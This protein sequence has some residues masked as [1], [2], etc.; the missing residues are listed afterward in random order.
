MYSVY[1]LHCTK[2]NRRKKTEI[3]MG[4]RRR[5]GQDKKMSGKE[6]GKNQRRKHQSRKKNERRNKCNN[7]LVQNDMLRVVQ[8]KYSS[9]NVMETKH[10]KSKQLRHETRNNMKTVQNK[11]ET[12]QK[13]CFWHRCVKKWHNVKMYLMKNRFFCV[14]KASRPGQ[15]SELVTWTSTRN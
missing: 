13:L 2:G 11:T 6:Q 15:A 4:E 3:N 5:R 8:Y 9:L 12:F 14:L 10:N 7:N 1:L